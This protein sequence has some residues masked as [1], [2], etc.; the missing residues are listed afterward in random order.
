MRAYR[1]WILLVAAVVVVWSSSIGDARA[2]PSR[3]VEPAPWATGES[4]PEDL[5]I[6]FVA[7]DPGRPVATWFGHTALVVEDLRRREGRL[8]NYGMFQFDGT[9]LVKFALGRL[10]F[11]VGEQPPGRT[12]EVYKSMDRGIRIYNLNLPAERKMQVAR[13]LAWN[14]EPENSVYLYHHY[15]DNCATR[16][17]DI[18]D[19]AVDGELRELASE[20]SE[21]TLREHTR[22][23]THHNFAM[24]LLLM[25][26]MNDS[27]DQPI[28]HWD[29]MFLPG[30]LEEGV[31]ELEYEGPDGEQIPFVRERVDYYEGGV[32]EI[33]ERAPPHW[34]WALLFGFGIGA[35]TIG[36]AYWRIRS[37]ESVAAR[38][39]FGADQ[40]LIG[41]VAGLPGLALFVMSIATDHS[42]TYWN[43]NLLFANPLTFAV[44]PLGI[45]F[46]LGKEWVVD[47]LRAIWVALV[48]T[49]LLG[50]VLKILPAFDQQNH[51][52]ISFL[53]PITV[54]CAAASWWLW[55]VS[56][57]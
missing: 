48:A 10:W 38:I 39:A 42:V 15:R 8:Y 14:V 45:A 17:R 37:P 52:P 53:L 18:I 26:M 29:A 27:I 35:A 43:E 25:Y 34:P 40:A 56:T 44:L 54:C 49:S 13:F 28:E 12:Y 6:Q 50:I 11:W 32:R 36:S 7:F 4:D 20:S 41:L 16:P 1:H 9:L 5:R 31:Q 21:L 2:Q 19:A 57:S 23:Y 24:D 46:A 33:P 47:W 3:P 51:L 30:E 22:R 55:R